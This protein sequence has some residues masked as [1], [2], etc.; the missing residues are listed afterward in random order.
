MGCDCHLSV[1]KK[2]NGKWVTAHKW[3]EER[4]KDESVYYT[5]YNPK[6]DYSA[7]YED[8]NYNYCDRNYELFGLLAG[9]RCPHTNQ[10]K[11]PSHLNKKHNYGL[12]D[13]LSMETQRD[14]ENWDG[15]GHSHIC[16]NINEFKNHLK[17]IKSCSAV[18]CDLVKKCLKEVRNAKLIGIVE[19]LSNKKLKDLKLTQDIRFII[20]FD[21]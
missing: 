21:N 18:F 9:V 17:S 1:E 13:N 15:D 16:Y 2:I 8:D 3:Y 4:F 19:N 14:V 10:I 12:P 5:T 7:R 6:L 11:P 20:F